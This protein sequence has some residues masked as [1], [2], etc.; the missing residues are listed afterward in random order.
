MTWG[1][2]LLLFL[3][4]LGPGIITASADNDAGGI[5]TYSLA[6]AHYGYALLW[7]ML[8]I[9]VLLGMTQELGVRMGVATGK[10][11]ADLLRER[12]RVR[13][14][15]LLMLLLVVADLGNTMTEF[16][17]VAAA[18]QVL[19]LTKYLLVPLVAGVVWIMVIKGS[20]RSV[21][22]IFLGFSAVYLSYIVSGVLS[23]PAWSQVVH[24]TLVPDM[25]WTGAFVVM[26]VGV[27]GTTISPWMQFYIQAAVVQKGITAK[28]Y[29]YSRLDAL[30]GA[31]VTNVVAFFIIVTTAVAL[32]A[33]HVPVTN[34]AAVGQALRPLAGPL[35]AG[36]FALGLLNASVFTAS[37]LPLST[38]F[39]VCEGLGWESGVDRRF[40]EAP[41]FYV[42]YTGLLVLG[43]LI[44]LWPG[45]PLIDIMFFSQV[46]NG[47]LLPILLV[48]V[49]LLAGDRKIMRRFAY[50]NWYL[51]LL[52]LAVAIT[53]VMDL[54]F[55]VKTL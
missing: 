49:L 42:F 29:P 45:A 10:G 52:W 3:A 48:F 14:T 7:T 23:H 31:V 26:F 44:V 4:V 38:A 25:R 32:F 54:V 41:N 34:I 16:A 33:H 53:V 12:F 40:R 2:R 37:V 39:Y 51:G 22:R 5:T 46:A 35:A 50:R 19:G 24:A 18:G 11:L 1:R 30:A 6:G 36:L 21:E 17:G 55:S 15:I 43:A 9:T 27:V 20:Y 13:I 28:E 8:P 47:L